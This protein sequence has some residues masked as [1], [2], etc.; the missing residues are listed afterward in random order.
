MNDQTPYFNEDFGFDFR[1]YAEDDLEKQVVNIK[2]KYGFF[3]P[4]P[5][6]LW[7][8]VVNE[9]FYPKLLLKHPTVDPNKVYYYAIQAYCHKFQF[10]YQ[11]LN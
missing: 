7:N 1:V 5:I 11:C 10:T 4:V 6:G 8:E 3:V 2:D 9:N